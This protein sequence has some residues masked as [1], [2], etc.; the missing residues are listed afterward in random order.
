[1]THYVGTELELFAQATNWKARLRTELE[2]FLEGP[3][4]E[5]GAGIGATTAMLR[6]LTPG[7]W[8]A[9]EPD[10]ELAHQLAA[11]PELDC[12]VTTGTL[13]SLEPHATFRTVIYIDVLEHIRDDGAEL[14]RAARHL[15]PGGQLVVLSPAHQ[16]L[17]S[18]FDAAIGHFRRYRRKDL[19]AL[20][21]AGCTPVR[22]R[23]LDLLGALLSLGNRLVARQSL[24]RL[25]QVL[26]WDRLVVPLGRWLDPLVAF[27]LGRSV[28][29][30]WQRVA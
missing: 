5:V 20:T 28:L 19:L 7:R 3:V 1:M 29:V 2:P 8:V 16:W 11:R 4:L 22:V 26:F 12:E 30:V 23:E 24:P 10:P 25:S 9:L 21:P 6:P 14:A 13:E 15:Q 18:P 27:R 17:Y